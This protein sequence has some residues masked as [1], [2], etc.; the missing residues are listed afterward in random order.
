M[1]FEDAPP[2]GI[3]LLVFALST[4]FWALAAWTLGP[5]WYTWLV[6]VLAAIVQLYLG[7]WML[8]EISRRRR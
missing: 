3:A 6:L 8:G 5:H 7:L 2:I 1:S 4:A